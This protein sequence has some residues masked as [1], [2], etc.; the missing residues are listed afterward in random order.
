L[1]EQLGSIWRRK[2]WNSFIRLKDDQK[3]TTTTKRS[4]RRRTITS[5]IEVKLCPSIL[6]PPQG[7]QQAL[8]RWPLSLQS[9]WKLSP[10]SMSHCRSDS[11][12]T[13]PDFC[14]D[15]IVF[16]QSRRESARSARSGDTSPTTERSAEILLSPAVR[17]ASSQSPSNSPRTRRPDP[18]GALSILDSSDDEAFRASRRSPRRSLNTRNGV[19]RVDEGTRV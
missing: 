12:H 18:I 1:K 14:P 7:G 5:K 4:T 13:A 10:S 3:Q 16:I 17:R 2:T 15:S 9:L 19:P 6:A 11:T 8:L